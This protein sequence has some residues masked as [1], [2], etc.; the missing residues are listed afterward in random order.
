MI[1]S[2]ELYIDATWHFNAFE[3]KLVVEGAL[4]IIPKRGIDP[5]NSESYKIRS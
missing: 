5:W 4:V 3:I 2:I 1:A